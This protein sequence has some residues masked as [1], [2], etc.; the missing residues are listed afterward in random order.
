[1]SRNTR[2]PVFRVSEQ[3]QHKQAVKTQKIMFSHDGFH[4]NKSYVRPVKT[5]IRPFIQHKESV[6]NI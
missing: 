3:V 2:K 1:M 5:Q 4:M 6:H